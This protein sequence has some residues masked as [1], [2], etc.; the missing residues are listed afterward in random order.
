MVFKKSPI[1]NVAADN[2]D[3][4][5][6]RLHPN[7]LKIEVH[8]FICKSLGF[9]DKISGRNMG[10]EMVIMKGHFSVLNGKSLPFRTFR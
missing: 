3:I 4:G 5:Q 1:V 6:F 2:N 9:Y 7:V 10:F 8:F